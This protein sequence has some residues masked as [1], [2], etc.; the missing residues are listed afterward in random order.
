MAI[1][2]TVKGIPAGTAGLGAYD[3]KLE[4]DP[5]V[6]KVQGI[7]SD[8]KSFPKPAAVNV[9]NAKGVV[10]LNGFNSSVPGATGDITLGLLQVTA[11]GKAGDS[12]PIRITVRTLS[13]SRGDNIA[14]S[15]IS[16]TVTLQGN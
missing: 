13:D 16:G 3:M 2:V 15:V 6:I 14:A 1:P 8:E 5:K 4:F 7:I 10:Y 9:D 12:T 11:V